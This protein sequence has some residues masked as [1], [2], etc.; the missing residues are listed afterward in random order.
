MDWLYLAGY[1]LAYEIV[2]IVF[3]MITVIPIELLQRKCFVKYP[4]ITKFLIEISTYL[5]RIAI[6]TFFLLVLTFIITMIAMVMSATMIM[7]G[8]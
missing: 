3:C 8:K 5:G 7:V 2:V 6:L 1:S 4:S